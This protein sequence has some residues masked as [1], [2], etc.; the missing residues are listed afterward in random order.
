MPAQ[1]VHPGSLTSLENPAW[2]D[3]VRIKTPQPD[4][5]IHD[6][7][8]ATRK[9]TTIPNLN[10]CTLPPAKWYRQLH[11]AS[12]ICMIESRTPILCPL[13]PSPEHYSPI[14]AWR[15]CAA[16]CRKEG[17]QTYAKFAVFEGLEVQHSWNQ[18]HYI[19]YRWNSWKK[20]NH[21]WMNSQA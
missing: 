1:R 11:T 5:E 21:N 18:S 6:I 17:T 20:D 19:Q 14:Q 16:L 9:K 13:S 2:T 15:I 3:S 10:A 12:L 7:T 4:R 8:E